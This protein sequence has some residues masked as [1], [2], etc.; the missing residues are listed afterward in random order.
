MLL[1][2]R[3]SHRLNRITAGDGPTLKNTCCMTLYSPV[4]V[5][6]LGVSTMAD[7][8]VPCSGGIYS[9]RT[10]RVHGIRQ[11]PFLCRG[12]WQVSLAGRHT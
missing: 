3:T 12:Y 5:D 8:R 7:S 11:D 10:T 1:G 4:A 6:W 2:C 9:E